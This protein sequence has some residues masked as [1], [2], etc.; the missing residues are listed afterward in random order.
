MSNLTGVLCEG[1]EY[2]K[3]K[4]GEFFA[5]NINIVDLVGVSVLVSFTRRL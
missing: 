1:V 5:N 3:C 4:S 2:D